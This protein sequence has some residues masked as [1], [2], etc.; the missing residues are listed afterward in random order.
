MAIGA[1]T[2]IGAESFLPTQDYCACAGHPCGVV[3]IRYLSEFVVG[4]MV[5]G[6]VVTTMAA[7]VKLSNVLQIGELLSKL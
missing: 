1:E 7:A 4:H 5:G 6:I 3:C 2:F